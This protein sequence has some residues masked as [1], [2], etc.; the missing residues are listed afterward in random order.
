MT[1][2]SAFIMKTSIWKIWKHEIHIILSHIFILVD[3]VSNRNTIKQNSQK[4]PLWNFRPFISNKHRPPFSTLISC[5]GHILLCAPKFKAVTLPLLRPTL[6]KWRC[7]SVSNHHTFY[8]GGVKYIE[9]KEVQQK[10]SA[11]DRQ[12]SEHNVDNESP[13]K[14]VTPSV[15][16]VV[17]LPRTNGCL[18]CNSGNCNIKLLLLK[19]FST[20]RLRQ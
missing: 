16:Q 20:W 19:Q 12:L 10:S 4:L 6:S 1:H 5:H 18:H 14:N 9:R 8:C 11:T 2:N 7:A 17:P 15:K 13:G 3:K